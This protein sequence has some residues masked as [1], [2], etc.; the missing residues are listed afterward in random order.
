MTTIPISTTFYQLIR[1][2]T[3]NEH[4]DALVELITNSV[5]AYK[6]SSISAQSEL[7]ANRNQSDN[8]QI[9]IYWESNSI[10]VVDQ[11]VGLDAEGLNRCFLQVGN[12]T[13]S[14]GNRGFFSR[15]AKDV[16]ALGDLTITAIKDN[17]LSQCI[18]TNSLKGN[19]SIIDQDATA[20]DH[21]HYKII[22]NGLHF[23]IALLPT[24]HLIPEKINEKINKLTKHFSL[25]GYFSDESY[26]ITSHWPNTN[27]LQHKYVNP[28]GEL[29]VDIFGTLEKF[30]YPEAAYTFS[31]WKS[32][33]PLGDP[34]SETDN[35][36]IDFGIKIFSGS[37]IHDNSTLYPQIRYESNIA[38]LFGEL[39]CDYID[40]LM[41]Q[42]LDIETVDKV[43]NPFP[44]IDSGRINGINRN[45]PFTKALYEIPYQRLIYILNDLSNKIDGQHEI[46]LN[47]LAK[48][49]DEDI[50]LE[51]L[52]SLKTTYG[53]FDPNLIG[54]ITNN[55]INNNNNITENNDLPYSS[56]QIKQNADDITGKPKRLQITPRFTL[57]QFKNDVDYEVRKTLVGYV[58]YISTTTSLLKNYVNHDP[59]TKEITGFSS[60]HARIILTGILVNAV[61]DILTSNNMSN[62][63]YNIHDIFNKYNFYYGK[64]KPILY[65]NIVDNPTLNKIINRKH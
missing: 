35:R 54:K 27:T 22:N 48:L 18:L 20:E 62:D 51:V 46:E 57:E 59:V 9:D 60:I 14:H 45:H 50:D 36:Y 24:Y 6:H 32:E 41:N 2:Q 38:H 10:T 26:T 40:V 58:I 12:Y 28:T 19:L 33:L 53:R 17:K 65:K 3:I 15:G 43:K 1:D 61:C 7:R 37:N 16:S 31:L 29:I 34:I 8:K 21:E 4:N 42:Y 23:N 55:I 47:D 49:F 30:G 25:R 13:S 52:Q 56:E 63:L 44:I 5:D 64:V 39:H 11:A